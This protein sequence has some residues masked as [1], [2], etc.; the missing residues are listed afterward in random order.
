[1]T[2]GKLVRDGFGK[3]HTLSC[4]VIE[5]YKSKHP[6]IAPDLRDGLHVLDKLSDVFYFGQ[7]V[8][9]VCREVLKLI[10][11]IVLIPIICTPSHC[12]FDCR[13][14]IIVHLDSNLS[15]SIHLYSMYYRIAGNFCGIY[16]LRF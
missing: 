5:L 7:V 10:L 8:S 9:I 2:L 1:M 12:C 11:L 6:H 4:E 15:L 13:V 14:H 16:I 3:K